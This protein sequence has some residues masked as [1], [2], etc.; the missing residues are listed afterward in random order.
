MCAL[1][2]QRVGLTPES[3]EG[4]VAE[5]IQARCDKD[6]GRADEIR[7]QLLAKRCCLMDGPDGTKWRPIYEV[8]DSTAPC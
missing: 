2:L 8:A 7:E 1:S 6:W 3:L 5:R 4:L